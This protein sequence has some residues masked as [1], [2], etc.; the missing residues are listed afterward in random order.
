MAATPGSTPGLR[1][2]SLAKTYAPVGKCIYCGSNT[3]RLTDEHIIAFAMGGNHVLP[4]ASCDACAKVTAKTEQFCLRNMIG[5]YRVQAGFPTRR[6]KE[7]PTELPLNYIYP[8]K[9]V[10]SKTVPVSEHPAF[11]ALPKFKRVPTILEGLPPYDNDITAWTHVPNAAPVKRFTDGTRVGGTVFHALTFG[12]MLAKIAH[13]LAA[14]D[15]GLDA[16]RPLL[17][18]LILERSGA[19]TQLIGQVG[20]DIPAEEDIHRAHLETVEVQRGTEILP[21]YLVAN[22]RLFAYLGSPQYHVV[23]GELI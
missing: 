3:G 5:A 20:E 10:E 2:T 15:P 16:F 8:D 12:R 22:I 11:L 1:I 17:L 19:L 6:P 21:Q 14:A 9:R 4:K 18:D 23:V 7:R 13:S